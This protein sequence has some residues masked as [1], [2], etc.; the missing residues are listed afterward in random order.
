MTRNCLTSSRVVP[1]PNA[2][3]K[4]TEQ[5]RALEGGAADN[6]YSASAMA[7]MPW[8]RSLFTREIFSQTYFTK[9]Q[10][11]CMSSVCLTGT[12]SEK[13]IFSGNSPSPHAEHAP[14]LRLGENKNLVASCSN[15]FKRPFYMDYQATT[16]MDPRVLDAMLPFYTSMYGNP[17]SRTHPYGWEAE[18]YVEKGRKD[19][20][21][22]INAQPK[23]IFF[24]SGA[25]ESN[26]LAIK[27]VAGYK[28]QSGDKKNH[29]IT[30]Q[31]EHKCLLA[32]CRDLHERHGWDVTYL[33]VDSD[34]LV[35]PA[36]VQQNANQR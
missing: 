32:S 23:E 6:R 4:Q 35:D 31:I 22:L 36:Q 17:H 13:N 11:R 24:T 15:D 28:T 27:G 3:R 10:Q 14:T 29:I 18:H 26:N 20:A 30:S 16:P 9:P 34:G 19:V 8:V 33:P 1:S 21:D 12:T 25:T 2:G 7:A 5:A